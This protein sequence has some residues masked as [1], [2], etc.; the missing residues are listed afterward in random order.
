MK[1]HRKLLQ[2][3]R[4][5]RVEKWLNISTPV[6]QPTID[7]VDVRVFEGYPY[8]IT[9]VSPALF[10]F[11][12]LPVDLE[13]KRLMEFTRRQ[14]IFNR[15]PTCLVLGS[16]S[17]IYYNPDGQIT[18]SD[19]V[20]AGAIYLSGK[21]QPCEVFRETAELKRRADELHTFLENTP[22]DGYLLGDLTKGGRP[23]TPEEKARMTGRQRNGIPKGL[24]Q[25]KSCL[26]WYG[27]CLD[28][29]PEFEGKVMRV[30]CKCE[31][32]NWCAR[33]GQPLADRRLNAN[34]FDESDGHIRHVPGFTGLNH[35]CRQR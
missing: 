26:D 11:L 34:Y 9:R 35:R 31:N 8:V 7:R 14:L 20:P 18:I 16:E 17:A 33:C 25:C 13:P 32:W 28:P 23:A 3:E 24:T 12:L 1:G 2:S 21:L 30:H 22:Q 6:H 29:N 4:S 10:H 27:V 5:E 19:L 15:L